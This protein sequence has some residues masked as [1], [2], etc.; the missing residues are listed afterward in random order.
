MAAGR[1]LSVEGYS[2][3][4][5]GVTLTGRTSVSFQV[6]ATSDAHVGLTPQRGVFTDYNMYEIVLG[7][8]S[9]SHTAVRQVQINQSKA[10]INDDDE[11]EE[12]DLRIDLG[13][14]RGSSSPLL[15]KKLR[16]AKINEVYGNG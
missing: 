6:R 15:C 13:P 7:A 9:N 4:D 10:L 12:E 3:V 2:Y 5:V 1:V 16:C 14:L 11:E 8:G